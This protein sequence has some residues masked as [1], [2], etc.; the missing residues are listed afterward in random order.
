MNVYL[1]KSAAGATWPLPWQ[2]F[3][4]RNPK[5]AAELEV[6]WETPPL[7][8]NSLVAQDDVPQELVAKVRDLLLG[9]HTHEEGRKLL[10]TLPLARFEDAT[11][12]TYQP[13][14]DFLK[15]YDEE[16]H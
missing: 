4:E 12:A 9:L 8:N 11:E 16:I 5:M 15:K 7:V 13:V 1:G 3:M 14:R 10:T 2:V 6:K